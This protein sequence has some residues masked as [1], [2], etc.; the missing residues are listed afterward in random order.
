MKTPKHVLQFMLGTGMIFYLCTDHP[1]DYIVLILLY[2]FLIWP[3]V[4]YIFGEHV[5][6]VCSTGMLTA[7]VFQS[8]MLTVSVLSLALQSLLLIFSKNLP[9]W[10]HAIVVVSPL[11]IGIKPTDPL[12]NEYVCV[13]VYEASFICQSLKKKKKK[14]VHYCVPLGQIIRST[15]IFAM[16]I[17]CSS[18]SL[19]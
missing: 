10:S 9:T 13:C 2:L 4:A 3:S 12:E 7:L 1:P 5:N 16:G 17:S 8:G 19:A 18:L 15:G 11:T 14:S 6:T